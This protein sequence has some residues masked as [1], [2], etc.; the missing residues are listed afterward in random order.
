MVITSTIVLSGYL[1]NSLTEPGLAHSPGPSQADRTPADSKP[2]HSQGGTQH[3]DHQHGKLEVPAGQPVPSVQL[4]VHPDAVRGV[5]LEMIVTNFTF[6]PERV[7]QKS[8]STEGHAHLFING[9]KVTRLY[10]PWYYLGDLPP[11]QHTLTVM[12]SANGHEDISHNGKPI[13][14]TQIVNIPAQPASR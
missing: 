13:S 2:P 6:A 11:G 12:L 7:N 10:G 8:L 1:H 14:A 5:N 9:R 3:G 4:V